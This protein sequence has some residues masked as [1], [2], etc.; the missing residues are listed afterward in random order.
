MKDSKKDSLVKTAV[1]FDALNTLSCV[2]D[3]HIYCLKS[4]LINN[5][6]E[7]DEME[8]DEYKSLEKVSPETQKLIKSNQL[9]QLENLAWLSQKTMDLRNAIYEISCS[10]GID[11][12]RALSK[13]IEKKDK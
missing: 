12:M 8:Q 7:T 6:C 1:S 10:L 4:H 3:G 11:D 2:I 9:S 13:L 5:T